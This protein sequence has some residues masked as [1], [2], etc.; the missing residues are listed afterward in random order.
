MSESNWEKIA[1]V[2]LF[3][4]LAILCSICCWWL[5]V[6]TGVYMPFLQWSWKRIFFF[7]ENS[8]III[9]FLLKKLENW[10]NTTQHNLQNSIKD[11]ITKFVV[12]LFDQLIVLTWYRYPY[13]QL[14][15]KTIMV[16]SIWNFDWIKGNSLVKFKFIY[17]H[18]KIKNYI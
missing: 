8:W 3:N 13:Q 9:S 12:S 10:F 11:E 1:G 2:K 5:S 16:D 4:L 18:I 14:Q 7:I 17:F 15:T 6:T